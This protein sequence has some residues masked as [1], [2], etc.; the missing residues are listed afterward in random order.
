MKMLRFGLISLAL[1]VAGISSAYAHDS[2]SFGLEI[3]PPAY[4]VPPPPVRYYEAPPTVYYEPAP[5]AYYAP[6]PPVYYRHYEPREYYAYH[7]WRE[8]DR[9]EWGHDRGGW[10]REHEHEHD[11]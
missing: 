8:H 9:G 5:R 1:G 10:G 6:P 2:F 7:D 3:A 4:Y 11:R